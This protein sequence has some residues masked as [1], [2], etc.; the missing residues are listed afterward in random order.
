MVMCLLVVLML[1]CKM[2]VHL[3]LREVVEIAY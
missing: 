1:W 3:L 2:M